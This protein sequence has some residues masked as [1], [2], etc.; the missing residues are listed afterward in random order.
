MENIVKKPVY[1]KV[2]LRLASGMGYDQYHYVEGLI[3]SESLK[4]LRQRIKQI[5]INC[6][7]IS[8]HV[9]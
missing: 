8:T 4:G 6:R 5:Y 2:S 1:S 3:D 9:P 7:S